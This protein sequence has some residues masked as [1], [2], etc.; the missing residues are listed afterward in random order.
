MRRFIAVVWL[1]VGLVGSAAA[2]E[3]HDAAAAGDLAAVKLILVDGAD[4]DE[5][6]PNAETALIAAALANQV[7]IVELLLAHGADIQARNAG[8]FTALHAAAY[9][10]SIPVAQLLLDR[11]A[12]LEGNDNKA[13]ATPLMVAAEQGQPA[14]VELFVARGAAVSAPERDG[15]TPL[16]RALWKSHPEVMRVLK[17]H[18][19]TCQPADVLGSEVLY[20]ECLAIGN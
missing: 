18:G 10:G 20:Q 4:V 17:S 12:R 8:G 1:A 3:L 16:T 11:G 5:R 14:L 19:A 6:G 2:G 9:A 15:Y 7:E 13:G